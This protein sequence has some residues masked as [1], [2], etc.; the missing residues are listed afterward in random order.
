MDIYEENLKPIL[1]QSFEPSVD[2][3]NEGKF[4]P[5]CKSRGPHQGEILDAGAEIRAKIRDPKSQLAI[6]FRLFP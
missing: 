6:F 5:S 4:Q 2:I 1:Y 3:I